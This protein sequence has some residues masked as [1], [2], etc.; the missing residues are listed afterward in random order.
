MRSSSFIERVDP[1]LR[2]GLL[3][4]S[5]HDL[6]D[7]ASARRRNTPRPPGPVQGVSFESSTLTG[8]GGHEIPVRTYRPEGS[9]SGV[10]CWVHG[11]GY[12]LGTMDQDH[13]LLAAMCV[14]L[15]CVVVAMDYRLAPE[16]PFPTPLHDVY[17]V[18]LWARTL[19]LE[20][21][22]D[23]RLVLAGSSA[24]GGLAA[25]AALW[26]R[27]RG[28]L[29]ID[30]LM[31]IAP[32]IDD[33]NVPPR[34]VLDSPHVWSRRHN[35]FG[36]TAY[37]QG[38]CGQPD[39]PEAAAPVRVV[40]ASGLPST[41][42]SVGTLD[43]FASEGMEFAGRLLSADVSTEVHVYPGGYHGFARAVPTAVL[44]RIDMEDR[45]RALAVALTSTRPDVTR[46]VSGSMAVQEVTRG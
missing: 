37:L 35:L 40:D 33:G 30:L 38:R 2:T 18:A 42:L 34:A 25:G 43:L 1:E 17:Q 28:D 39:V 19:A 27:D 4:L 36:W 24:G 45:F 3:R 31:L 13:D 41:Y 12:V 26:A 15:G 10:V 32:M 21:S 23:A 44:S 29:A 5:A 9:P 11:G 22:A 7:L 14:R 20:I 8:V 46:N 6:S 16:H